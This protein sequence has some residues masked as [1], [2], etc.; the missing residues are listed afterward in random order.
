M[1]QE[2]ARDIQKLLDLRGRIVGVIQEHMREIDALR[3]QL[4]GME[5]AEKVMSWEE[6]SDFERR[7]CATKR[8][9]KSEP[10]LPSMAFRAYH[11]GFCGGWHLASRFKQPAPAPSAGDEK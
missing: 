7:S 1:D 4:I 6:L 2:L 11:C 5:K 8:R 9:Y 3:N 10:P